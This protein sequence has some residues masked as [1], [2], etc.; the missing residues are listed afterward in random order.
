MRSSRERVLSK[1]RDAAHIADNQSVIKRSKPSRVEKVIAHLVSMLVYASQDIERAQ[2]DPGSKFGELVALCGS[3]KK[4]KI[5]F[6]SD[7][8]DEIIVPWLE[9]NR[10]DKSTIEQ[11][12][13]LMVSSYAKILN[14]AQVN[15]KIDIGVAFELNLRDILQTIV[16]V[17]VRPGF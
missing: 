5:S 2:R 6:V 15:P 3:I 7:R 13:T 14:R 1:K 11:F 9:R 12:K 16:D 4:A 10:I 8:F 17:E